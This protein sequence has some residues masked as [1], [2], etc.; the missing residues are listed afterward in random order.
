MLKKAYAKL[1]GA[2][3]ALTAVLS[4]AAIVAAQE[5]TLP[6]SPGYG[7]GNF[8]SAIQSVINLVFFFALILVLI[9]LI[10]GGIQWITSGGDKAGT[11]AARGKITGAIVGI[12]IV[13][14][15]YAIYT[16]L[17]Q[18]VGAESGG[19]FNLRTTVE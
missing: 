7:F 15:A 8:E 2:S 13:A 19:T 9:Y 18:F 3:S 5:V 6:Q 12:I 1:V 4:S 10:W 16:I 17:V 11:E 14:V